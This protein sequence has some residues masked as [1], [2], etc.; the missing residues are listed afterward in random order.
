MI[1]GKRAR[2]GMPVVLLRDKERNTHSIN[3]AG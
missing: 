2:T 1:S 3:V